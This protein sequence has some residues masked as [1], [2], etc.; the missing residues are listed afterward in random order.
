MAWLFPGNARSQDNAPDLR[1]LIFAPIGRDGPPTADLLIHASLPCHLCRSAA[2]LCEGIQAGAGAVVLTDEALSDHQIDD[3]AATLQAQPAWSDISVLLFC[4]GDRARVSLRTVERLEVLRNVTLLERPVHMRALVSAVQ[5]ALRGRG[6]QYE[7][8]DVLVALH[9][10]RLE[11]EQANRLKDEFLATLSHELRTPLNAIL[12]WVSM[13][14]QSQ[15]EPARV[16]SVLEIVERNAR[17]QAQL[18]ADVLDESRMITGRVKLHLEPTLVSQVLQD[19]VDSVRPAAD[20]K[21]VTLHLHATPE[22]DIINGD[23]DRLQQVFWNLLSNAVKF[24]PRGGSIEVAIAHTGSS[25]EITI[26]DTGVGLSSEFIPFAFERFRQ[27]DQSFTRTQGGL[28]LG[29]AI[30]KQ[31]VEMHGGVV[32]ATSEGADRG[33]TFRIRL[34][35]AGALA[36][37]PRQSDAE[38][39][40]AGKPDAEKIDY[41]RR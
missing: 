15:I 14:R 19:A 4:R 34:P 38:N 31:L 17:V 1:V 24:T 35:I 37:A 26:V 32:T 10:A 2:E 20:A 41:R 40:D 3:L 33:A 13:L 5:A 29:L 6:R 27:A 8:R 39:P 11:A 23:P 7:L 21:G 28:G 25:V 36:T 12:G 22:V 30:V 9:K 18:I 16:S